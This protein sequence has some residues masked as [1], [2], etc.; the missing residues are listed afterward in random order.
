MATLDLGK[1]GKL[2]ASGAAGLAKD[3]E[4]DM[5]IGADKVDVGKLFDEIAQQLLAERFP[6]F[7]DAK[8]AGIASAGFR[9]GLR[10]KH[11]TAAGDFEMADGRIALDGGKIAVDSLA[12]RLPFDVYFPQGESPRE[13]GKFEDSDFGR[14]EL[15]GIDAG[16][17]AIQSLALDVALKQNSLRIK[18]PIP[19]ALFGGKITVSDIRGESLFGRSATVTTS[20]SAES[21]DLGQITTKL[22]LPKV[23]GTLDA[24]LPSIL[25]NTDALETE[26]AVEA[27]VFG[28]VIQAA[29]LGI[30][31]PFSPVRT[32]EADLTFKDIDLSAVTE[33]LKFGTITGIMD[34]TLKGLEISQ[35]QAAAFVADFGTVPRKG[36]PQRINFD[37]VQNI[38]I[39]GT[40]QGF[41]ATL[42]RGFASFFNEFRYDRL[43]FYC[44]LKN[45]N[46]RMK[47]K[48]VE[49]GT[50][51]FVRGAALG[52][53]IN[54]IN[55]NPGQTVSFK[56]M[57]ERINRV[58]QEKG[59]ENSS[60]AP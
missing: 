53:S 27:N 34:G 12:A 59:E 7:R 60:G 55:R 58:E 45:D 13:A 23:E 19:I 8:L 6:S 9:L 40:G 5:L 1:M 41:Q 54:V 46:F 16:P 57:L 56:S 28:G 49:G 20:A 22:E 21:M 42:G 25:L 32:L 31:K 36:V 48:V 35:G 44:T 30:E 2:K 26:G 39:L 29:G 52:P 15:R 38:T 11:W 14:L 50:E 10:E 17:A 3:A 43:G 37:A 33:T 51:Y 24:H 47:G 4:L 18:G